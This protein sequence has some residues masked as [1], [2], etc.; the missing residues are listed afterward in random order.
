MKNLTFRG[1]FTK[2]NQNRWEKDCLER[3]I[4]Q[5]VDLRRGA[6]QERGGGVLRVGDEISNICNRIL[7]N[8]KPE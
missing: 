2:K 6:S 3:G 8:K 7:T 1:V 5:F 4:G